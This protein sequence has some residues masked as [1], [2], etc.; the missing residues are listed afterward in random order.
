MINIHTNIH[1]HIININHLI[2]I[3][4]NITHIHIYNFLL[5]NM[6]HLMYT[7]RM[8]KTRRT[9]DSM[10]TIALANQ[11]G[12]V[13]KTTT[14]IEICASMAA[15]GK[16]VLAIDLDQSR[17]LS[18]YLDADSSRKTINE[19]LRVECHFSEAI[20]HIDSLGIDLIASSP[21]LSRADR[22]FVEAQD[23]FLLADVID[24]IKNDP[25]YDYDYAVIDNSPSRSIL[26]TMAYIASDYIL[27]ATDVD[28]GSL[29]GTRQIYDDI[30]KLSS[31]RHAMTDAKILGIVITRA[32]PNTSIYSVAHGILSEFAD[33]IPEKPFVMHVRKSTVVSEAKLLRTSIRSRKKNCK[34]AVDYDMITDEI[35][36]RTKNV[37][38]D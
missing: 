33:T 32:E 4:L 18:K 23:P 22:D 15:K 8:Y 3:M 14:A 6:L 34:P 28:D 13:G 31:S 9:M 19:V 16:K 10:I 29:D 38:G 24:L 1:I 5:A 26:L 37:Q 35:I 30:V 25:D 12:G 27:L 7:F 36:N 17:N 20:Q 11:K 21:A 2:V